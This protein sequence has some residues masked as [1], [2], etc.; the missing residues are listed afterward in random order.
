MNPMYGVNVLV[1]QEHSAREILLEVLVSLPHPRT[2]A[3]FTYRAN[4]IKILSTRTLR[5]AGAILL[6][7][8]P[9]TIITSDWRGEARKT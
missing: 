9:A 7:S 8:V 1:F 3:T 6:Q 5:R 2:T 4:R